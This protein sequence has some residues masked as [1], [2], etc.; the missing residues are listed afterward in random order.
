[1]IAQREFIL[2]ENKYVEFKVKSTINQIIFI[3]SANYELFKDEALISSGPCEISDDIISALIQPN[4]K[5]LFELIIT[6][7]IG[8]ETRKI[9]TNIKVV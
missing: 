6:Y 2:G 7:I 1:M 3:T 4:E 5:G 9:R 8:A